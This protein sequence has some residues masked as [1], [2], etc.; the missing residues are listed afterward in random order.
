MQTSLFPEV[1][2]KMTVKRKILMVQFDLRS[3]RVMGHSK[4]VGKRGAVVLVFPVTHRCCLFF[5]Q[6]EME[7]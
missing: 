1:S 3:L 5:S 4:L 2:V 6:Q 7:V